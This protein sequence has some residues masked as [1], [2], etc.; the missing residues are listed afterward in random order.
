MHASAPKGEIG[1]S[2]A[3]S[4]A[5]MPGFSFKKVSIIATKMVAGTELYAPIQ[6]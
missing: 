2:I 3:I 4:N 1:V 5:M 6:L